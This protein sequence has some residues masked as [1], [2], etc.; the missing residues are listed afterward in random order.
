MST[1][2]SSIDA[3][4]EQRLL[5]LAYTTD[6]A[7]TA[8][9]LAYFAPCSIDDAA[10]V[11]ERLAATDH[12]RMDVGDDG[13]VTYVMPGRQRVASVPTRATLRPAVPRRAMPS[14]MPM[15]AA[16]PM[17]AALLTLFLPGA[18]HLYAGRAVSAVLWFLAITAGYALIVPGLVLHLFGIASAARAARSLPARTPLLLAA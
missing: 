13:T 12:L 5:E 6:V 9:A 8:P 16:S 3:A 15:L 18:G 7:L 1:N 14:P 10:R 4:L 17:L 11:L 2:Q